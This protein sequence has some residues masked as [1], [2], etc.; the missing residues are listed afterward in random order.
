[1]SKNQIVSVELLR[2][3]NYPV[4]EEEYGSFDTR[5]VCS[6]LDPV[7]WQPLSGLLASNVSLKSHSPFYRE[8]IQFV[9]PATYD[10]VRLHVSIE[11]KTGAS[12]FVPLELFGT[13]KIQLNHGNVHR[14]DTTVFLDPRDSVC[15]RETAQM[16]PLAQ[17]PHTPVLIVRVSSAPVA[18]D[19]PVARRDDDDVV[20]DEKNIVL[21]GKARLVPSGARYIWMSLLLD[22]AWLHRYTHALIA[23]WEQRAPLREVNTNSVRSASDSGSRKNNANPAS[24]ANTVTANENNSKNGADAL[25]NS[26]GDVVRL[27]WCCTR[28]H[29]ILTRV[30][31]TAERF[32]GGASSHLVFTP[33]EEQLFRTE[34]LHRASMIANICME[35][36]SLKDRNELR[37]ELDHA[38]A[39]FVSGVNVGSSSKQRALSYE[40]R[41]TIYEAQFTDDDAILLNAN[42]LHFFAVVALPLLRE[43]LPRRR[44]RYA[45]ATPTARLR[46]RG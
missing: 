5:V 26:V 12:E 1:M 3:K 43:F 19:E 30:R 15:E 18:E 38:Y 32:G 27:R 17:V 7:V 39:A 11:R 16:R 45:P 34:R 10:A 41:K 33:D 44:P 35:K 2:G 24:A 23:A 42:M 20:I 40:Q 37:D 28:L 4:L 25:L 22:R 14:K 36:Y 46:L 21:D 31:L 13:E 29:Q 8:T 9:I 6:L